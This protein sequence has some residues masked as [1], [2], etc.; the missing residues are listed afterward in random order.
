MYRVKSFKWNEKD[1][2]AKVVYTIVRQEG[3]ERHVLECSDP[4]KPELLAAP[5]GL[6]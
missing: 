6:E 4:P 1:P 2:E 3:D 5:Q